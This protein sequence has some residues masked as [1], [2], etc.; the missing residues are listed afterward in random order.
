M[1]P[2]LVL[3]GVNEFYPKLNNKI[4]NIYKIDNSKKEN[5]MVNFFIKFMEN[6]D[7]NPTEKH[8]LGIDFEF[9]KV[10]KG[11]REVALMQINLENDANIGNIFLLYPPELSEENT[12]ILIKLITH[13]KM[14]KILHGAESL[15]VPYLF[16]Q[17][18]ISK[19]NIENFCKN[20]YD[21]KYLCDYHHISTNY[22]GRCS[23]YYLLVEH[24]VMTQAKMDELNKIEERSGPI[25]LI[26]IDIHKMSHDVFKYSLYDVIYLP[27]LIK[28][29]LSKSTVYS[30]IL[31]EITC[32]VNKYKRD[33]ETEF[34][35]LEKIINM[36]NIYFIYE[37]DNIILLKDIWEMY[38]NIINDNNKYFESLKQIHYFK[39]FF[40]ILTKM[41][42]YDNLMKFFKVYSRKNQPAPRINFDSYKNWI[43]MYPHLNDLF[44]EYKN[45]IV[46]DLNKLTKQ[47]L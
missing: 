31:P 17:L 28:K 4:Y 46:S 13:N 3:K 5:L 29:F 19:K 25:Y 37:L 36:M 24:Q 34:Q 30:K 44:N 43:S 20:F 7:K 23:I 33:I 47:K 14:I 32:V 39:T 11:M 42:V 38:W 6:Q 9:N 27:E 10:S 35:N 21:T 22:L 15:D 12:Q 2:E 8:Y 26:H 45:N 1:N 18:L 41:I 40:E 16:N